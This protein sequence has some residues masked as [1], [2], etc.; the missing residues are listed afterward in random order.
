VDHNNRTATVVLETT[1]QVGEFTLPAKDEG[2]AVRG[3]GTGH[4]VT[5]FQTSIKKDG[6]TFNNLWASFYV[7]EGSRAYEAVV[8]VPNIRGNYCDG[9]EVTTSVNMMMDVYYHDDDTPEGVHRWSND[10]IASDSGAVQV[11][12]ESGATVIEV[13][14]TSTEQN[15]TYAESNIDDDTAIDWDNES[16]TESAVPTTFDHEDDNEP[17]TYNDGDTQN[18]RILTRHYFAEFDSDFALRVSHG[19]GTR[20]TTQIETSA[21]GGT[22][23]YETPDGTSLITYLHVTENNVTVDLK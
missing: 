20:G 22:I 14:F 23:Q 10:S 21:S 2:V 12:C 16:A 3:I 15:L 9:D 8:E 7:E 1:S 4:S 19:P 17:R 5:D 13:N 18:I 11:A 6:G